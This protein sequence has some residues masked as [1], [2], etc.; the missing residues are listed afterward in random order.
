MAAGHHQTA[1][2]QALG[3]PGML[4]YQSLYHDV[5]ESFQYLYDDREAPVERRGGELAGQ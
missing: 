3:R 2:I 1:Y 5:Y 4:L